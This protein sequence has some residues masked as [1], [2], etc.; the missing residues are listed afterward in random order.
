MNEI[1]YQKTYQEYKAELDG[2]LQRTAEGFVKIGY[3]LKV[4]RDTNIL[5]E[6]GY[7][8]VTEFAQ[9]EYN[10]DKTQV[11][12]FIHINDKFSEGGY[13]DRLAENYRG[14]GYAKLTIMLQLPETLAEEL[15]P[16]FSKS[17]IQDIKEEVDAEKKISDI[18]VMLEG[19]A[20]TTADIEDD[21]Q[22]TIKQMGE[23]DPKLYADIWQQYRTDAWG[24]D[25]LQEMLAPAG[26]KLFSVRIKGIGRKQMLAKD[27]VNGNEIVLID[28]RTSEKKRYT[29]EDVQKAWETIT[30][31]EHEKGYEGAWEV[32]YYAEWPLRQK[33]EPKKEQVAPVQ[34]KSEKK[35][36]SKVKKAQVKAEKPKQSTLHEIEKSIPEPSTVEQEK[37]DEDVVHQDSG[38]E[39][40]A[41]QIPGQDNI[42]NHREYLP[43]EMAETV[44]NTECGEVSDKQPDNMDQKG[45]GEDATDSTY[46]QDTAYTEG[47]GNSVDDRESGGN[48]GISGE[49][50]GTES[51]WLQEHHEGDGASESGGCATDHA[52]ELTEEEWEEL[53]DSIDENIGELI[54][55]SAN[56][57]TYKAVENKIQKEELE[58]AY[59]NA[60]AMAAALE[61][62]LNGKKY[63]A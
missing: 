3:L 29:W 45:N 63:T 44:I 49:T 8:N 41:E 9:E 43:G 33:E 23:D 10:I 50:E 36:E 22:K 55:F 38:Q 18:E 54:C 37:C 25:A 31:A 20:E 35:K 26:Q 56:H 47:A 5:A 32:T 30:A 6:S 57:L 51:K 28:L 16:D 59:K 27:K 1:I 62:M 61:R 19:E 13:S 11:S 17:E 48:A 14:F 21:L 15:T 52:V 58:N 2:E 39:K 4:A 60:I 34:Q 12:R 24:V 53:W 7:A 40:E 42:L 46:G